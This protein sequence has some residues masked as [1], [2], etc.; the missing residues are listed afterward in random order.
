ML[1]DT[2]LL[3]LAAYSSASVM[4]FLPST[5]FSWISVGLRLETLTSVVLLLELLLTR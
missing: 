2:T 3:T 4:G 1:M 5:V